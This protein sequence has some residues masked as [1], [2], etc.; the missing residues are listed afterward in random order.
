MWV[1]Q[2][3]S[4]FFK[5]LSDC[6]P[7]WMF[8]SLCL[9]LSLFSF[10]L[11]FLFL[12]T[13]S[14]L[15]FIGFL[16]KFAIPDYVFCSFKQSNN[17]KNWGTKKKNRLFKFVSRKWEPANQL[18]FFLNFQFSSKIF[19]WLVCVV[20]LF[21]IKNQRDSLLECPSHPVI[22]FLG[23]HRISFSFTILCNIFFFY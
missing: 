15:L 21:L 9:L 20:F 7:V 4:F 17:E 2:K 10:C 6:L 23:L 12:D 3:S 11:V 19:Y 13:Y 16:G 22:F 1:K 14:L 5:S 18:Q 8:F